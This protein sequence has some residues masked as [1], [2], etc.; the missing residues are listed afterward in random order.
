M[1]TTGKVQPLRT[2]LW[3]SLSNL[4]VVMFFQ[5]AIKL[6]ILKSSKEVE[7]IE[8]LFSRGLTLEENLLFMQR[9]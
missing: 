3:S 2:S 9:F 7:Q 4:L 5:I 6:L 1:L 8:K